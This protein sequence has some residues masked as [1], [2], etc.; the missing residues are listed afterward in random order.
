[1]NFD[2]SLEIDSYSK[3]YYPQI[4]RN[5]ILKNL[6]CVKNGFEKLKTKNC[7]KNHKQYRLSYY[8]KNLYLQFKI[9]YYHKNV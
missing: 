8:N 5:L 9:F 7:F 4:L 2:F 3:N 1:M 6:D